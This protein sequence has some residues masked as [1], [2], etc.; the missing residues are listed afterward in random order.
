MKTLQVTQIID[1]SRYDPKTEKHEPIHV[2]EV[3]K[4]TN[5]VFPAVHARLSRDEI[6]GYCDDGDWNVTIK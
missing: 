5:A 2:Y 4:V 6:A 1:G 3:D